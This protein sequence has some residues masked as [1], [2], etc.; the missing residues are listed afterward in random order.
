MY[1]FSYLDDPWWFILQFKTNI[2]YQNNIF[3]KDL[4]PLKMLMFSVVRHNTC[5]DQQKLLYKQTS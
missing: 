3:H 2:P 1:D 4:T 5:H